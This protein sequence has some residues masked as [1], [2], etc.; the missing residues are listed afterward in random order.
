MPSDK[1]NHN[2]PTVSSSAAVEESHGVRWRES[3]Q[4]RLSAGFFLFAAVLILCTILA[5]QFFGKERLVEQ[6]LRLVDEA[7]SRIVSDLGAKISRGEALCRAMANLSADGQPDEALYRTVLPRIMADEGRSSLV[8]GGGVWPEPYAFQPGRERAS[9]FWGRDQEGSLKFYNEYNDP[10]GMGYH[11]EEWYVPAT[12][13]PAGSCFWSK[14][15]MDPH[16]Y[17]PMVTCTFP[18]WRK[19][20]LYGVETVDLR[21]EGLHEF[22]EQAGG[23]HSGYAFA[24]DRNNKFLSFP[25][26]EMTRQY[27]QDDKG[28][29]VVEFIDAPA[30]GA[31]EPRFRPIAQALARVNA[32]MVARAGYDRGLVEAIDKG[33]YQIDAGEAR[34]IAAMFLDPLREATRKSLLL[35]R[36]ALDDDLLLHEAVVVSIYHM[37]KTY[38]KVVMVTPVRAATAEA[39]SISRSILYTLLGVL[40]VPLVLGFLL[41]RR[42]VV[43]PLRKISTALLQMS[44]TDQPLEGGYLDAS[45]RDELGE[46]AFRFNQ[47]TRQ[48]AEASESLRKSEKDLRALFDNMQDVF[49]RTDFP[50]AITLV[51]PSCQAVLGYPPEELIGR[52]I[53]ETLYARPEERAGLLARL[54][55]KGCVEDYEV[56]LRRKDGVEIPISTNSHLL[57]DE[58]GAT[59]GIEGTI[60]DIARRKEI[61]RQMELM[62]VYL[63][64]IFDSMPSVL[65]GIDPQG[66]VTEWNQAAVYTTGIQATEAMGKKF[67]ELAALFERYKNDFQEVI[68]SRTPK[69]YSRQPFHQAETRYH[70]VTLFP[71]VANGVNG[72]VIRIDDMTEIE[73][74]DN[75]LRQAQKMETIG[76]LAGGLAHDFNNVLS[77]ITGTLSIM[78]YQLEQGQRLPDEQMREYFAVIEESAQRATEVVQQLLTLSRKQALSLQEIDLRQTVAHV[79]KL[80]NNSFDKCIEIETHE[81]AEPAMVQVDQGQL[82]QVLLNLC[83]NASHAM[84]LMRRNEEKQGGVMSVSID[85]ITADHHFITTHPEAVAQD[86]WILAVRDTGVGIDRK[87]LSK[88]FDPFYT[89]KD[90]EKGTGLGLAMAYNIIQQ[91]KGFIDVYSEV[92]IGT[93]FN[94]FLPARHAGAAGKA[95]KAAPAIPRGEGLILVVDDEKT[96]RDLA[97]SILEACGYSVVTAENGE[98][99]VEIFRQRAGEI[100]AVLMDMVMPKM[101]G[102][103]ACAEILRLCPGARILLSSGFRLD[104]RIDAALGLGARDFIQ[105]PYTLDKLAS[106]VARLLGKG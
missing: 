78:Q 64:N 62:R 33:S 7:G 72:M 43:R 65:I 25:D 26:E 99:G 104:K 80:C 100:R 105:K 61:E 96:L 23:L 42:V 39:R 79:V 101:D 85:R 63:K 68:H 66:T 36:L 82:E 58:A 45:R 30:L 93:T 48:L 52:D 83:V 94:V 88:I 9:F 18:I 8:A 50:G 16:S 57:R 59:T 89:T 70:D 92:G 12:R 24:L 40:L 76:I 60:R 4:F 1:A 17:Q 3:L 73:L 31:R 87:S 37:P 90:K 28:K 106:A 102:Q 11:H 20:R 84:T 95:V 13:L 103:T 22:M 71:L 38:W 10:Q 47:R 56:A 15:Y 32:G 5:F 77:G 67:W 55:D 14:S 29:R 34:L 35:D 21:L 49:Y 27:A 53:A 74:K 81:P 86:Y 69:K 75:Q 19:D 51:S 46:L 44:R 41:I 91:H 97:K 54:L 98:Q 6:N 2:S